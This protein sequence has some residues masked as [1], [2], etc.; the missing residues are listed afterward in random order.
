MD[1]WETFKIVL[2][3]DL[4]AWNHFVSQLSLSLAVE[5]DLENRKALQA[6][7]APLKVYQEVTKHYLEVL[8]EIEKGTYVAEE[9]ND[10]GN[11]EES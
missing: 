1:N 8:D 2:E 11:T 6:T 7:L 9:T 3:G 5:K 10:G 4:E